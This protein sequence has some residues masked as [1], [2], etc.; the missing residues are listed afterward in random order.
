MPTSETISFVYEIHSRIVVKAPESGEFEEEQF[1]KEVK[2][3]WNLIGVFTNHN[4]C[5]HAYPRG[6]SN[7]RPQPP[8]Y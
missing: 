5:I 6:S 4:P 1:R 8:K 7:D 3:Y 2:S